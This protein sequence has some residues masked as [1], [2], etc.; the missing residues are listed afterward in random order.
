MREERF[1]LSED[2]TL[3]LEQEALWNEAKGIIPVGGGAFICACGYKVIFDLEADMLAD[4]EKHWNED[5]PVTL[6]LGLR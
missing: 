5:C 6:E 3:T 4:R 2:T 1:I